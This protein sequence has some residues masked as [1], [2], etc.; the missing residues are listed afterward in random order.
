MIIATNLS[1]SNTNEPIEIH[2]T[3]INSKQHQLNIS[4]RK[5]HFIPLHFA[6]NVHCLFYSVPCCLFDE[7]ERD[8]FLLACRYYS[9]YMLYYQLII[10][11][12]ISSQ[13]SEMDSWRFKESAFCRNVHSI[14]LNIQY[15][16]K[17]KYTDTHPLRPTMGVQCTID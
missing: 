15:H 10:A 17:M 3:P 11:A 8:G 4:R 14:K 5:K 1:P 12:F 9:E 16:R 6:P 13:R 2:R 7:N